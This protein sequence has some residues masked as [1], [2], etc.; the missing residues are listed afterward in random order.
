MPISGDLAAFFTTHTGTL[1]TVTLT[2][3][4][5]GSHIV[6]I[7]GSVLN[8]T[9]SL[10]AGASGV[11][12]FVRD[13]NAGTYTGYI[14][15]SSVVTGTT[16]GLQ[17]VTVSG[18]TS[19][20]SV[21]TNLVTASAVVLAPTS[22]GSLNISGVKSV[23]AGSVTTGTLVVE[24]P[25]VANSSLS[26]TVTGK[27]LVLTKDIIARAAFTSLGYTSD[28]ASRLLDITAFT[29]V[30]HYCFM[31]LPQDSSTLAVSLT[32]PNPSTPTAYS[33]LVKTVYIH[34]DT[35]GKVLT[36]VPST[37]FKIK[38]STTVKAGVVRRYKAI[39]D[40]TVGWLIET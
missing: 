16:T 37:Y 40:Q 15:D 8:S 38:G 32:L 19:L 9:L 21:S 13:A 20:D 1:D 12:T 2:I 7:A 29:G 11:V 23:T 26:H 25:G 35:F 39:L 34:N 10:T 33:N 6:S 3:A 17:T 28:P 18:T 27:D 31:Q 36:L 24:S 5:Q 22:V 14:T 4:N 30:S